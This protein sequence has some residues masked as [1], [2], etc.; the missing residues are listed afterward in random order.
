MNSSTIAILV[1]LSLFT[2]SFAVDAWHTE[3]V[4]QVPPTST[5]SGT[6]LGFSNTGMPCI[7]FCEHS[8]SFDYLRIARWNGYSWQFE[9]VNAGGH[10]G[11]NLD[12]EIDNANQPCITCLDGSNNVVY[13]HKSGST[14]QPEVVEVAG[15]PYPSIALDQQYR[16]HL[17]YF[18]Q[19]QNELRYAWLN[20]STWQFSTVSSGTS[21]SFASID[22]NNL[23]QPSIA[24]VSPN[25]GGDLKYAHFDG[26]NWNTETVEIHDLSFCP[27]IPKLK[28]DSLNLP[29]IAYQYVCTTPTLLKYA[30]NDGSSWTITSLTYYF[31]NGDYPSL[32]VDSANHPYIS[33]ATNDLEDLR[34]LYEYFNGT[35]WQETTPCDILDS[36]FHSSIFVR[37]SG[38]AAIS[39]HTGNPDNR[40]L[41]TWFGNANIGVETT[42]FRAKTINNGIK[43]DWDVS[44]DMLNDISGF[45]LYRSHAGKADKKSWS[46]IN[47]DLITGN[48]PYS[49]LDSTCKGGQSYLYHLTAIK[50][51]GREVELGST[52]GQ[53]GVLDRGFSLFAVY[54]NPAQSMLTCRLSLPQAGFISLKLYDTSGRLV[55]E[56]QL[57]LSA[58]EQKASVDVS[59]LA[60]GIYCL[61]A[62]SGSETRY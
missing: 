57:D 58:G 44:G 53:A 6:A 29:H 46:R 4:T 17:A 8:S 41:Y 14:W 56:K 16:P 37:Y 33:H 31:D 48:N 12:M 27:H 55:L 32:D 47:S 7:V 28:M 34:L 11:I 40:L 45:N 42:N 39:H 52:S 59:I 30:H 20:G 3:V 1:F 35:S 62:S 54:P 9:Q 61:Q 50:S 5:I 2:P 60:T 19:P 21:G 18:K 13:V 36:G 23:S 38:Y 49:Y 43:L 51:D 15:S 26:A 10:L 24:Y 25:S 22:L